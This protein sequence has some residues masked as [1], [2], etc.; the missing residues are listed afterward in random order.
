MLLF[1]NVKAILNK[2]LVYFTEPCFKQFKI[3]T[4]TMIANAFNA[5]A[6]G[7]KATKLVLP[8]WDC[9]VVLFV[10]SLLYD[11]WMFTAEEHST[12]PSK[13]STWWKYPI[14]H[15]EASADSEIPRLADEDYPQPLQVRTKPIE[16]FEPPISLRKKRAEKV[17]AFEHF[18]MESIDYKLD[19]SLCGGIC[20]LGVENTFDDADAIVFSMPFPDVLPKRK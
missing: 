5:I 20:Y 9:F 16:M 12:I 18:P 15:P 4:L 7:K 14:R 6:L 10:L 11:Y 8:F 2:I 19:P 13:T 1:M 17:I 3:S